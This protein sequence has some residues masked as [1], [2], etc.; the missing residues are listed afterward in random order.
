MSRQQDERGNKSYF[1]YDLAGRQIEIKDA[2]NRITTTTYDDAGQRKSITD[3]LNRTTLFVYDG[4]GRMIETIYPDPEIADTDDTNNPRVKVGYD[5]VG[6]KVIDTDEMGRITR[7]SY[8]LLSRLTQVILPNPSNGQN[9]PLVDGV[10]PAAAGTLVTKY[11]YDEQGNKTA[12]IDAE[13]RRTAW[14]FD[15]VG[16]KLTRALPMGQVESNV[17]NTAGERT[18]H[19]S[20]NA[21]DTLFGY[22]G[23]GR[24]DKV[25]FP[26]NRIRQFSYDVTGKVTGIDDGGQS[27]AFEYDERDRLTKAIDSYGRAIQYQYDA[28]G[29]RTLLKTAKQ[30]ISYAYDE[31][32]R[33]AEVVTSTNAGNIGW[34]ANQKA[35]YQYDEVGNRAGMLNPNGTT[36]SYQYDRRNRLKGLVHKASVAANAALLLGLSYTVDAS[37]LR[38]RIVDTRPTAIATQTATRTTNYSYDGVKRLTGEQVNDSSGHNRNSAWTYGK[39][40]NRLTQSHSGSVNSY[41]GYSYDANDRLIAEPQ[42]GIIYTHDD[43]GNLLTK[44]VGATVQ[45]TYRWDEENRMVGATIG[46]GAAQ[47]VVSYAYDPS[48]I[49]RAQ[50]EVAGAV[51]KRTEYLADPNQAYAQ[52]VEEWS[53]SGAS[54]GALPDESIAKTYIFGDDLISQTK[55]ALDGTGTNSFYHYDGLGTTRTLTN[56][57]GAVTDRNAY[58]A[59]GEND[60]AGTSGWT[61]GT[62]DNN[63]KYTGEQLDPNLGFYYLRARYMNPST[64]GFISQDSYMGNSSDPA[65]LHK[66]LYA[67]ANPVMGVDPSGHMTLIE[68]TSAQNIQSFTSQAALQIGK[69]SLKVKIFNIYLYF[70]IKGGFHSYIF[71]ENKL[72]PGTGL[73]FDVGIPGG[74]GPIRGAPFSSH[75]GSLTV[76]PIPPRRHTGRRI[77][78]SAELNMIQ[79]LLWRGALRLDA[80]DELAISYNLFLGVN[81]FY[82]SIKASLYAGLIDRLK[83]GG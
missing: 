77:F 32:N 37:G 27:Y 52:V 29:N 7:F 75:S 55:L 56:A 30:E 63:F 18:K 60:P 23:Q 82:W 36:V 43:N 26:N 49:R 76:S 61:S 3:A 66:Y 53:A 21:I 38:T 57:A 46:V 6:R 47:K 70:S 33:L 9:P 62:T 65:S 78:K 4:A 31:L 48:G 13:G 22:D 69:K 11:E 51:R 25:T 40:G 28:A 58:T 2:L 10:S 59:F 44:K 74:W 16:R 14:S 24:M 54:S 81:C 42:Q 72:S 50:E 71:A 68:L 83:I 67:N 45:A 73:K 79:Y 1:T 20:F 35:T 15:V 39:T 12:Q 34:T 41:T 8:D 5:V 17:Y 19:T 80:S 64:G